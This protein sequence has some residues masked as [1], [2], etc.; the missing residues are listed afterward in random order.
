EFC[1]DPRTAGGNP[2]R[3]HGR[4]R[5]RRGSRERGRFDHGRRARA[6]AGHQL[7]GHACAWPGVPVAD[8]RALPPARPAADGAV[9]HLA[10]PDELHRLDRG[11][12]R[13]D[14]RHQRLRPRAHDPHR[15]AA[16]CERARPEPAGTYL[17]ADRA[18]RWRAQPRGPH[19]SGKRSG[20]A[21]GAG[22]GRRAGGDPQPRRQHG[23]PAGAGGVRARARVED[24]FDRGADPLPAGDR[25]HDR[26]RRYARDRNRTRRVPAGQLSRPPEPCAALRAAAWRRRCL[27]ADA[28]ARPC[29]EPARRCAAL[30]PAGLRAGGGRRAGRD[31]ARRP[32][33]AGA[34]GRYRR[35]RCA[36]CTRAPGAAGGVAGARARPCAGRVAAHRRGRADPGRPRA[37]QAACDRH[38]AQADRPGGLRPGSGRVRRGAL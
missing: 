27:G 19:R 10:A 36:A 20:A 32:R 21:R 18:A 34:A 29:A 13:R 4:D 11:G 38:A 15:G 7:H 30:A 23:A 5:R 1:T 28:R 37:G 6:A 24:R 26:A 8:A 12:R 33:R 31:R 22:A 17:P 3:P 16:R 14:H 25:A 35:R 9:Q 2:R